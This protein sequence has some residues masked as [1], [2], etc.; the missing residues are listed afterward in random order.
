MGAGTGIV[1]TE[2]I[3]ILPN[4]MLPEGLTKTKIFYSKSMTLT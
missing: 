3:H 4:T 1:S 2:A